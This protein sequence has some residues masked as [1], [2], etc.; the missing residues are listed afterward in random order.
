MND[1]YFPK[2]QFVLTKKEK[3]DFLKK[4]PS[5][6]TIDEKI[7]TS[8]EIV[9]KMPYFLT[10]SSCQGQSIGEEYSTHTPVPYITVGVLY[11][12]FELLEEL[13]QF[14]LEKLKKKIAVL[15]FS[16]EVQAI[17]RDKVT[18][19][20]VPNFQK[21]MNVSLKSQRSIPL[22]EEALR[23]FGERDFGVNTNIEEIKENQ[24][25][26]SIQINYLF[27]DLSSTVSYPTKREE[28]PAKLKELK[29]EL[30]ICSSLKTVKVTN[31]PPQEG[32]PESY[33]LEFYVIDSQYDI[34]NLFHVLT[35]AFTGNII[36]SQ[37][38]QPTSSGTYLRKCHATLFS[39]AHADFFAT[40]V[41]EWAKKGH[42]S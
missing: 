40:L 41:R 22:L 2:D 27:N 5:M 12:A 20:D 7:K 17:N 11:N 36:A 3:E 37:S 34:D 39:L 25:R 38:F 1:N 35:S 13:A 33:I 21:Y 16:F 8:V 15:D 42:L 10:Q 26:Q 23:E 32:F 18:A 19:V 4:L 14:L 29:E 30:S 24:I 31:T 9:N 6:V 28:V